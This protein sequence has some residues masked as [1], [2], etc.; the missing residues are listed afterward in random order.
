[1]ATLACESMNDR[2]AFDAVLAARLSRRQ[3]LTTASAIGLA[4]CAH[5]PA[6]VGSARN[7]N[8]FRS[9]APQENDS[10]VIAD[11]YRW[12]VV[13]RWGDSLVAGTPDFDTRTMTDTAWLDAAAVDAQHRRFGTNADAVQYFPLVH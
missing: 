5:S 4:A 8:T 12:N 11:G 6:R 1:M 3:L 9:I 10:F 2:P 13:A 7:Q